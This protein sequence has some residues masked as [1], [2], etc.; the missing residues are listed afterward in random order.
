M[1]PHFVAYFRSIFFASMG[2]GGGQN[3]VHY[4]FLKTLPS[5]NAET[6]HLIH[7]C[8]SA[9]HRSLSCGRVKM[10]PFVL[11]AFFP[12]LK[13]IFFVKLE[14]NPCDSLVGSSLVLQ[15]F[16]LFWGPGSHLSFCDP[17]IPLSTLNIFFLTLRFKAHMSKFDPKTDTT[18]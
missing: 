5:R 12:C 2:G 11:L 4:P 15:A 10:E 14:A 9:P 8:C 16:G 18:K 3:C 13:V 17:E 1:S 6:L 7:N